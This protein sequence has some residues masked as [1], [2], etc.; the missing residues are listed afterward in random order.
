MTFKL[1]YRIAALAISAAVLPVLVMS[2]LT[3]YKERQVE[4]AI[5]EKINVLIGDSVRHIANDIYGICEATDSIIED[6]LASDMRVV[7]NYLTEKGGFSLSTTA[8]AKW[9]AF[10]QYSKRIVEIELPQML[11]GGTWLGQNSDFKTATPVVDYFKTLLGDN[12]TVFQRMN[13]QGDFIRVATNID[14]GDGSRA[15]G[16]FIPAILPDGKPNP[17][18][19]AMVE[20]KPYRGRAFVVN[21][22]YVVYYDPIKDKNGSVI[23]GLFLGVELNAIRT[24][25][26]MIKRTKVG[27]TGYI[28]VLGGIGDQRGRYI[29][30]K[31]GERDGEDIIEM[32]D[33]IGE[34]YIKDMVDRAVKL[35]S[36]E[37]FFKSYQWLNPGETVPRAKLAAVRYFEPWDWVIISS[38]YLDDYREIN[39]SVVNSMTQL[40]LSVLVGG[41]IILLAVAVLAFVIGGRIGTP[42]EKVCAMARLIA[43][44]DLNS[45][46]NGLV[47]LSSAVSSEGDVVESALSRDE[48][49]A[50]I[51]SIATMTKNLNSFVGQVQRSIIQLASSATEIA[52]SSKEQEAIVNEF[53]AS[54]NQIVASSKEI[55][56]TSQ[57]L[58]SSM[59]DVAEVSSRTAGLANVGHS[60][61][62]EMETMMGQL[63]DATTSIS[64]KL[65]VINEKA[66]NI[67]NVVTTITKVADQTNLLS[68]NA[69]IEAE[70][71]G[72]FGKGFSVVAREV[73]RLADQTAVATLDITRMVKEMQSAVSSGVMEMDKFSEEVRRGVRETSQ[74]SVQLAKIIEEVQSLPPVFNNVIEGMKQQSGGAKQISESIVQLSD[75][76]RQTSE[77][78]REF[79]QAI[80]QLNNATQGLQ[81][82]VSIFKVK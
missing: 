58:V 2:A 34:L 64:S 25:G 22:W 12:C 8:K 48:T 76:V 16:S 65:S 4:S 47:T 40:L 28:A 43:A 23:G 60:S 7:K 68:L 61:L 77:S 80:S 74:I 18:S 69:A 33:A 13:E 14:K 11:L 21:N 27:R 42:I 20:G 49:G 62:G 66:N 54:T 41:C 50:L 5:K 82:E 35:K 71:A 17:V 81:R 9:N 37:S 53:G 15:I 73:R 75:A 24:L 3:L 45:A 51:S 30:S 26:D 59:N 10:D 72:E 52:A 36:G 67:N 78:L 46:S 57:H 31:N 6:K 70:K 19:V 39:D 63:A 56:A 29:V 55:S 44:G 79:N 38:T 1:K 32:K